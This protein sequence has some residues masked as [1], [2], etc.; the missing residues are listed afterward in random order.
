M[1]ET[2]IDPAAL[3]EAKVL[4]EPPEPPGVKAC[5]TSLRAEAVAAVGETAV[6]AAEAKGF[7]VVPRETIVGFV[8]L[9]DFLFATLAE[10]EASMSGVTPILAELRKPVGERAKTMRLSPKAKP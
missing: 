7:V 6:T 4:A 3:P 10:I 2:E 8:G 5:L 1:A 9:D